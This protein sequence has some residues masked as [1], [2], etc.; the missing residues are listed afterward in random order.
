MGDA[1]NYYTCLFDEEEGSTLGSLEKDGKCVEDELLSYEECID[2]DYTYK[3]NTV[4][5]SHD[6]KINKLKQNNYEKLEVEVKLT[7]TSPFSK[8][9]QAIYV[10]NLGNNNKN[11]IYVDKVKD[12]DSYCEY[13]IS[14]NYTSDKTIKISVDTG[15]LLFDSIDKVISYT[16]NSDGIID[17]VTIEIKKQE[18]KNIKL[19]KNNFDLE[20]SKD[21]LNYTIIN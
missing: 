20:C 19:Y 3:L 10:L 6:F 18:Y 9:L 7:T 14:N 16:N 12:F 8:T 13:T 2:E 11:T 4:I 15:K 1:S 21:N 5:N 17:S